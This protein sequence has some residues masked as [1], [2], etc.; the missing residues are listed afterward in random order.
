MEDYSTQGWEVAQ[1]SR[2]LYSC[3]MADR[4]WQ[5]LMSTVSGQI[6]DILCTVTDPAT[7]QGLQLV[8]AIAAAEH[9]TAATTGPCT[10]RYSGLYAP[11]P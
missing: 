10:E 4:Q 3:S 8:S 5:A 7:L 2:F 1:S 9:K 6:A 11:E